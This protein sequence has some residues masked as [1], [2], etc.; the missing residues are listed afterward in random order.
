MGCHCF[1]PRDLP[2]PG[3]E[4]VSPALAGGL[5][6]NCTTWEAPIKYLSPSELHKGHLR[7][8][9]PPRRK[10]GVLRHQ[11]CQETGLLAAQRRQTQRGYFGLRSGKM[12]QTPL[13][14]KKP[15]ADGIFIGPSL[16][17]SAQ[18]GWMLGSKGEEW[19]ANGTFLQSP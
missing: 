14:G 11:G 3:I 8:M 16:G 1:P 19:V 13:S 6:T 2:N 4:S 17:T 9:E 18:S 10:T 12:L 5:F 15:Q 7:V